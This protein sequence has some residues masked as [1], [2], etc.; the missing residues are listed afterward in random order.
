MSV[1]F[2]ATTPHLGTGLPGHA[3]LFLFDYPCEAFP[4]MGFGA[5]QLSFYSVAGFPTTSFLIFP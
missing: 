2:L 1:E 5:G 3:P 4:Y